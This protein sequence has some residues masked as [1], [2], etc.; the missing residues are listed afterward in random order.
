MVSSDYVN[1]CRS[2]RIDY[3]AVKTGFPPQ[4]ITMISELPLSSLGLKRGDQL[5]ISELKPGQTQNVTPTATISAPIPAAAQTP[6]PTPPQS[7]DVAPAKPRPAPKTAELKQTPKPA[8]TPTQNSSKPAISTSRNSSSAE[9]S[10]QPVPTSTRSEPM[11]T[12]EPEQVST[13]SGLLV[14]RI[15]PDD[16]SCLFSSIGIVFEQD[17]GVAGQLR[18]GKFPSC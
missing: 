8:P 6:K 13:P 4:S 7:K 16:N 11:S 18:Q 12:E 15:V 1:R 10:S 5:I 2:P 14:H 17:M 9:L 3:A